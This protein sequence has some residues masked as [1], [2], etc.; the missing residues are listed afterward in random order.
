M[1]S[2]EEWK[3]KTLATPYYGEIGE[4]D[5]HALILP[6]YQRSFVWNESKRRDLVDSVIEGFPIGCLIVRELDTTTNL[7]GHGGEKFQAKTYEILDG[8]Q[9]ATTLILHRINPLGLVHSEQ[10]TSGLE[11]AALPAGHLLKLLNEGATS[12]LKDEE[13]LS[14]LI[15]KWM[16][17][18]VKSQI[19]PNEP[20]DDETSYKI[21]EFNEDMFETSELVE[22]LADAVG[23]EAPDFQNQLR[24]GKQYTKLTTFKN[25]LKRTMDNVAEVKIPVIV[26]SGKGEGAAKIFSRVNQGGVKLN[27]YQALAASW[28]STVTNVVDG[29][30]HKSSRKALGASGGATVIAKVEADKQNLDLYEALVGLSET[31]SSKYPHLFEPAKAKPK[32]LEEPESVLERASI[33]Y[34]AFN[35][36]ALAQKV[37]LNNL[38]LLTSPTGISSLATSPILDFVPVAEA[39]DKAAN[40]VAIAL[41]GLTYGIDGTKFE[42]AHAEATMAAMI[43]SFAAHLLDGGSLDGIPEK[44][45]VQHYVLDLI[46]GLEQKS[47]ASDVAAFDRIWEKVRSKKDPETTIFVATNYYLNPVASEDLTRALD[48]FWVKQSDKKITLTYD[49]RPRIDKTQAAIVR[50][51]AS[52]KAVHAVSA[53][54]KTFHMDHVVPFDMASKWLKASKSSGG[55]SYSI[56][57][58]TNLAILPAK[59]NISKGKKALHDFISASPLCLDGFTSEQVWSL[60]PAKEAETVRFLTSISRYPTSEEWDRYQKAIWLRMK[61]FFLKP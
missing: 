29:D 38:G 53:K 34:N 40:K 57:A 42:N 24:E 11:D 44:S 48:A 54:A 55:E 19:Y 39:V 45:I 28:S 17:S 33:R 27:R 2:N 61:T 41:T 1:P 13:A 51:F 20:V 47:H 50:L 52:P 31:L 37:P 12:P 21:D 36:V 23:R 7:Y 15:A 4:E 10:V 30:I 25:A 59:I 18:C 58:L 35:V 56:G 6:R 32:S 8:L 60:V 5:A 22:K 26:W 46:R 3:I 49:R 43:G 16:R 14:D 9:R